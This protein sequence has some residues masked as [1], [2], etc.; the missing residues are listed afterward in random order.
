MGTNSVLHTELIVDKITIRGG[1]HLDGSIE[2][3]GAKNAALPC[4]AACLLT[5]ETL[6]L[7]NLPAV[8][9]I[10]T[11]EKVLGTL[12]THVSHETTPSLL[13]ITQSLTCNEPSEYKAPYEL[14]KTMR[15][16]ILV[17]GPLLTRFG[18]ASISFPGG[19]SI[20][21]RP[22]DLH[23]EVMSKMGASID[24]HHGY[25][26]ASLPSGKRLKGIDHTFPYISVGATENSLLA[27]ALA[28]GKTILRNAAKEPEIS[29]L[30]S[31]LISMGI[32]IEGLGTSTLA[33]EGQRQAHG[34][35]YTIIPDRIE[36]GTF[37]CALAITGG[38]LCLQGVVLEH[39][40][41]LLEVIERSGCKYRYDVT[42][43]V[44]HL[45]RSPSD[46]L[47]PI[48][49]STAPYPDFPTDLQAQF[50]AVLT[51]ADGT[52]TIIEN[53]FE[54]RF[55]H[56]MELQRLGA[57]IDM[58]GRTARIHGPTLLSGTTVMASDLRASAGLVIAGLAAEGTTTIERIYHLDRGY[59]HLDHKLRS[60]GVEI[61]RIK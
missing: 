53:I 60:V 30:I 20:G 45:E 59:A 11:M 44:L 58:D 46:R 34:T 6:I 22:I 12:G 38:S 5:D 2:I 4:M 10:R 14:V 41:S 51:Q 24:I 19:C 54:N 16:S 55:Q 21:A 35:H 28:D 47:E 29:D 57:S 9:D 39:V 18:K 36:V 15:A 40:S 32:P 50:M 31:L 13:S 37:I 33:I 27:A 7:R 17:L 8:V 49:I 43:K 42:K 61:E 3:S 48:N 52:S 56:V 26:E 23:L 1:S 25:V